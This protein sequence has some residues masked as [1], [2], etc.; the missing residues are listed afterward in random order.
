MP[1]TLIG[2]T[3]KSFISQESV[4]MK[5]ERIDVLVVGAGPAGC[6]AAKRCAESGLETFLLE[7][8]KLPRDKVC[9]GLISGPMAKRLVQDEFGGIPQEVLADPY[10]YSGAMIHIP[11][12]KPCVIEDEMPVG[13]R[14]DIDFWMAQKAVEAGA[15]V[16][17][18]CPITDVQLKKGKIEVNFLNGQEESSFMTSY[19]VGGDGARSW[20]RRM[21]FPELKPA[22]QQEVRECYEGNFP[23]ERKYFHGFFL[24]GKFWFDI[25]HKGSCFCL[26]VSGK[27]GE[28]KKRLAQAK[29]ILRKEFEFDPET[30]PLRRD[31]CL[32]P[33]IHEQLISSNFR[34]AK[35]NVLLTGDAAGFQLPNSMGI[36]TALLSGLMAGESILES[37]KKGKPAG[38]LYLQRVKPIVEVIKSQLAGAL[39][40]RHLEM[41]GNGEESA[42]KIRS[43]F[44]ET[45]F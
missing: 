1:L 25:N 17:D 38:D 29:D 35:E 13:W 8:K 5:A 32:E 19:L 37:V 30:K 41:S 6:A 28:L 12:A 23:L 26:E 31:G 20:V 18:G 7:K 14:R 9:S 45:A 11:G 44:I 33:R 42:S 24:P 21:I 15:Q 36:G 22:Y 16:R 34:P 4:E 27:P 39:S 10:Y 40:S 3:G 43:F 2:G